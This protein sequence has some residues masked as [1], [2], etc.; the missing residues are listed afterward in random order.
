MRITRILILSILLMPVWH[1]NAMSAA[2]NKNVMVAGQNIG[3]LTLSNPAPYSDANRGG[4]TVS[5]NFAGN[6]PPLKSG[7]EIRWVQLISTSH[8]INTAT[9]AN[10]PYF[11]PGELDTT[12]DNDPFY[13]NTGLKANDGNNHPEFLYTN[14]QSNSGKTISFFDEPKRLFADKPVSW[15]AELSAVCWTPGTTEFGILWSG[16]YGFTIDNAGAVGVTGWNELAS[17]AY[18]TQARLTAAF[19]G[20]TIG[21]PEHCIT[22]EPASMLLA[23]MGL[24]AV[25]LRRRRAV[26]TGRSR[27]G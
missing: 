16:T 21:N 5:G 7:V 19:S 11:D 26:P 27:E 13:W 9:A 24:G 10:T 1:Q 2:V 12:G 18:L 20:W 23:A 8:P 6:Y 22:P 4:V 14:K 3:T 17:P 15:T 25:G